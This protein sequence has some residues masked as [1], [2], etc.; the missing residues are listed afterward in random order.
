MGLWRWQCR[1]ITWWGYPVG[2]LCGWYWRSRPRPR[3]RAA[4]RP[5]ASVISLVAYRQRQSPAAAARRA[6]GGPQ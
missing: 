1:V 6:L 3:A 4:E 2:W 5:K